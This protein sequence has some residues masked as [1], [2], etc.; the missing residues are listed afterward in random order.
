MCYHSQMDEFLAENVANTQFPHSTTAER[1]MHGQG[2][3]SFTRAPSSRSAPLETLRRLL[4]DLSDEMKACRGYLD[5]LSSSSTLTVDV[6]TD[7]NALKAAMEGSVKI[8]AELLSNNAS[9][10]IDSM[11]A[12][13]LSFSEFSTLDQEEVL[14]F[15]QDLRGV[16]ALVQQ[17][18]RDR[19]MQ[20]RGE[21]VD[22]ADLEAME[23][24]MWTQRIKGLNWMLGNRELT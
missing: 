17:A 5:S 16:G 24:G 22:A 11:L 2:N 21:V 10:W 18:M 4:Y 12:G 13:K 23:L 1:R 7:I 15:V 3:Y 20:R 9:E 6:T 19:A 14:E 8:L